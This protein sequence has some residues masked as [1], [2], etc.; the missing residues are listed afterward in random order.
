MDSEIHS[1]IPTVNFG[2]F[3]TRSTEDRRQIAYEVDRALR[4]VG[5]FYLRDHGIDQ[6]KID[7]YFE[8]VSCAFKY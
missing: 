3:S 8:M 2:A 1:E 5:F 4:S 6:E 7:T